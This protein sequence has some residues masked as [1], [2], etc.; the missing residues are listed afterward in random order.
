M[1]I[2]SASILDPSCGG[3]DLPHAWDK[4]TVVTSQHGGN[5]LEQEA[6]LEAVDPLTLL[7]GLAGHTFN[8]DIVCCQVA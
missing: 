4:R 5:E 8:T 3:T 7:R 6:A 2:V 1:A